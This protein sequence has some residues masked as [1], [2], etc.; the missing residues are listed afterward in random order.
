[1]KILS[2]GHCNV[3]PSS[4]Y[5]FTLLLW[6]LVA[7]VMYV[8]LRFAS[9]PLLLWNLQ[10]FLIICVNFPTIFFINILIHMFLR[11][12]S[13]YLITYILIQ[14]SKTTNQKV[15]YRVYVRGIHFDSISTIFLLDFHSVELFCLFQRSNV[16]M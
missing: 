5:I 3:C 1:V 12:L 4:L 16:K 2:C 11:V 10:T 13:P 8:L 7:I 15:S 14:C 6:Y 9:S